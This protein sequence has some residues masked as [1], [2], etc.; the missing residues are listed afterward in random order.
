[1]NTHIH[2]FPDHP[3]D[4]QIVIWLDDPDSLLSSY[5]AALQDHLDACA[6]CAAR[7]HAL[8]KV[9]DSLEAL[10]DIRPTPS[11]QLQAQVMAALPLD[12][13]P[14]VRSAGW[15][16]WLRQQAA[17]VSFALVGVALMLWGNALGVAAGWWVE[18]NGWLGSASV[19]STDSLNSWLNSSP[20][21]ALETQLGLL[22]GA[23]LLG[24]GA[25]FVLMGNVRGA[26][27][28]RL[29]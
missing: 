18:V 29:R 12:L 27:D 23:V 25:L 1:M 10:R 9:E 5:V 6:N 7:L 21:G 17:G 3:T 4:E 14:P 28:Y 15:A 22:P 8:I 13:Y 19:S 16:R 26:S 24:I 2:A 11:P 20:S